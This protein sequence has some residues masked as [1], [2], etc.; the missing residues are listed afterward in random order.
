MARDMNAAG[1]FLLIMTWSAVIC[2]A[3]FCAWK[4]LSLSPEIKIGPE[5]DKEKEN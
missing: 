5:E 2:V 1:W 3:G 4:M